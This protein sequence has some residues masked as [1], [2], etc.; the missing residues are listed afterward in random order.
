MCESTSF[1]FQ[2]EYL[3]EEEIDGNIY[4]A[5]E[6]LE[7]YDDSG[8]HLE[9]ENDFDK[10]NDDNQYEESDGKESASKRTVRVTN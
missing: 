8:D 6:R 3:A 9:S 10:L 2:E 5:V 1:E 4:I 7:N